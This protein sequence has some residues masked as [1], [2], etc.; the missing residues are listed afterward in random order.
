MIKY[1]IINLHELSGGTNNNYRGSLPGVLM[2]SKHENIQQLI[3]EQQR[4]KEVSINL[5]TSH[6]HGR[7][8]IN[9]NSIDK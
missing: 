8:P 2:K 6:Q 4:P 5:A 1:K 3:R 9:S 7:S